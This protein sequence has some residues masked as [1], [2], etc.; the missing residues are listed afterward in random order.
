MDE[1][2]LNRISAT[3]ESFGMIE[4]GEHVVCAVSGGPD[5]TALLVSLNE[6]SALQ[7][8]TLSIAHVNHRLRGAESGRDAEHTR[9][10]AQ[11]LDLPFYLFEAD[12]KNL[13]AQRGLS[14]QEAAREVRDSFFRSLL[15]EVQAQKIATGH[16]ATD[17]AETFLMRVIVGSGPQGLSGIPP[18]NLPYIRPLIEVTRHDVEAYLEE[19]GEAYIIDSSNSD[20]KYLRNRIRNETIPLLRELNPDIEAHLIGAVTEYRNLYDIVKDGVEAFFSQHE[21]EHSLAIDALNSLSKGLKSEVIKEFI[22]RNAPRSPR[23]SRSHIDA[24]KNLVES[25]PGGEKMVN[26]PAGLIARRS[27]NTLAIV[28]DTDEKRLPEQTFELKGFGSI[29]IPSWNIILTTEVEMPPKKKSD[30]K[31][32]SAVFDLEKLNGPLTLRTR[33]KGDRFYPSAGA[34]LKK[35]NDFFIDMK[36]P[37]NE[38]DHIPL[39]TRGDDIIWVAG[40]RTDDR[41]AADENTRRALRITFVHLPE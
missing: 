26:L 22:F 40:Y 32:N 27:Y 30:G 28:R 9:K 14:I 7:N 38:R 33:I 15:Q 19:K 39:L 34:G 6:L 25:P 11:R 23:L 17:N 8:L 3:V 35:L 4:K 18:V 13:A 24:V 20:P 36:I 29:R 10:L 37:R 16:T 1:S 12:V 21:R 31:G 5:S 41:Y 2:F